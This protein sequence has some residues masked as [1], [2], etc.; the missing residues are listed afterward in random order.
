MLV[1]YIE[2]N[3][4]FCATQKE[5]AESGRIIVIGGKRVGRRKRSENVSYKQAKHSM[6][7]NN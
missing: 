3:I 2:L 5:L 6:T 4:A 1:A 7:R